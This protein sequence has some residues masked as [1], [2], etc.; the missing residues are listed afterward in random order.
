MTVPRV[1]PWADALPVQQASVGSASR[2][3]LLEWGQGHNPGYHSLTP[4][5]W[6]PLVALRQARKEEAGDSCFHLISVQPNFWVLKHSSILLVTC[7]ERCK[8]VGHPHTGG[9]LLPP[10]GLK[11]TG[12][13]PG[14]AQEHLPPGPHLRGAWHSS[15]QGL[16]TGAKPGLHLPSGFFLPQALPTSQALGTWLHCRVGQARESA[17]GPNPPT[18]TMAKPRMT[19]VP[20]M[21]SLDVHA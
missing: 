17:L 21:L 6:Q 12:P 8:A 4:G 13:L 9:L 19:R 5:Q 7:W 18:T 11:H 16:Y 10:L 2:F 15:T 3:Q 20:M 1:K 14:E